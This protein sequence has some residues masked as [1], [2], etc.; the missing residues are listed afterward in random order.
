MDADLSLVARRVAHG[1]PAAFRSIVEHTQQESYRLAARILGSAADAEDV[2]QEAYVK[3]YRALSEGQFD[4]RAKVRTW[5]RRVVT[6]ACIDALRRRAARPAGDSQALDNGRFDSSIDPEA[7]AALSELGNWLDELPP[8][9]RAALVLCAVEG[10]T[11]PEAADALGCSVG[12]V[13]QR[14][15]RARSTLRRRRGGT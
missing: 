6:N 1:D 10:L 3:A 12:A 7:R 14:L 5:L 8:E 13:E 2:L 15:V 11:A 4:E 9:Q